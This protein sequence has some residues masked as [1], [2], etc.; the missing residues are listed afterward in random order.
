MKPLRYY[1]EKKT[2]TPNGQNVDFF[3][4][5]P[6]EGPNGGRFVVDYYFVYVNYQVDVTVGTQDGRDMARFI[7]R[8]QVIEDNGYHRVNLAGDELRVMNYKLLGSE[9]M[10]E[11][12]DHA[13]ANNQTGLLLTVI[14]MEKPKTVRP[15]DWSQP[16]DELRKIVV[17]LPT[18]ATATGGVAT[19][20]FDS[21]EIYIVSYGH[22]EHDLQF[23]AK[24]TLRSEE[25][26]STSQGKFTIDGK[27]HDLL[28][29]TPGA[30]GGA[31]QA[32]FTDI[33]IDTA[34]LLETTKK[35]ELLA[36]YR[37][38]FG[39]ANN[40]N[41]TIGGEVRS[42]PFA[43]GKAIPVIL[44][45]E[46]TS[47]Y[48]GPY[49]KQL[50]IDMTNTVASQRALMRIV[51]PA[52]PAQRKRKAADWGATGALTVKTLAKSQRDL[53]GWSDDQKAY[54]PLKA[55]MRRAG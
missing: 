50:K 13:V 33:R 38:R 9:K 26:T 36:E 4:I 43:S 19:I 52:D 35:T 25:F 6:I 40:L 45:D 17:Q 30:G 29:W 11:L 44:S 55:Q 28:I 53:A 18:T 34:N 8:I 14:P 51:Q 48:D 47:C 23:H 39:V 2:V 7:Q 31:S 12:L 27:L 46:E 22:E 10:S 32:N 42:D 54:L 1:S 15:R 24:D 16:A 49:I 20:A 37:F 41:S 21:Y 5:A 3:D